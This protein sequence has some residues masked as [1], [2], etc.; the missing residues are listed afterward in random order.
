MFLITEKSEV[1]I[2][3]PVI[4]FLPVVPK[5]NGAGVANAARL[6]HCCGVRGPVFGSP[7]RSGRLSPTLPVLALSNESPASTGVPV[8][9]VVTPESCQPPANRPWNGNSTT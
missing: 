7:T 5:V 4:T 3:G 2:P 8:W 9:N 1:L 6:N